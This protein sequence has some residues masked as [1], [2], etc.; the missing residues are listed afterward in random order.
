[1]IWKKDVYDCALYVLCIHLY[2]V[3]LELENIYFKQ[4]DCIFSYTTLYLAFVLT[5]LLV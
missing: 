5:F 2:Q 4:N 1:M 3:F